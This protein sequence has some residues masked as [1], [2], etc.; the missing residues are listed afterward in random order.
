MG[1]WLPKER[2]MRKKKKKGK[3]TQKSTKTEDAVFYNLISEVGYTITSEYSI[4]HTEQPKCNMERAARGSEQQ[5]VG[6]TE[7]H[8]GVRVP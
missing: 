5:K 8:L 3:E 4:G 6:I 7:S 1:S 2:V